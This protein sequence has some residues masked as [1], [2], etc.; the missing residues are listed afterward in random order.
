MTSTTP[1]LLLLDTVLSQE[2]DRIR[3][4]RTRIR[5]VVAK[6]N[7]GL[8]GRP[9]QQGANYLMQDVDLLLT[10]FPNLCSVQSTHDGS[11][12]LHFA[13]SIGDVKVATRILSQ[14]SSLCADGI[15]KIATLDSVLSLTFLSVVSLIVILLIL[16]ITAVP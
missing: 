3:D 12:P 14:V 13:A 15:I 8:A 11:L 6:V 1:L 7:L 2:A 16:L 10:A 4:A 5:Q 9:L